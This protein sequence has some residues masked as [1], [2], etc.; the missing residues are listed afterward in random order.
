MAIYSAVSCL[1]CTCFSAWHLALTL[2]SISSVPRHGHSNSCRRANLVIFR[3]L[4]ATC[5]SGNSTS[6]RR[7]I[8]C[9]VCPCLRAL[10]P[11]RGSW[12]LSRPCRVP[13]LYSVLYELVPDP[14][15]QSR[16]STFPTS[17]WR[18]GQKLWRC[19][20]NCALTAKGQN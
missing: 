12:P 8:S 2:I 15:G 16:H 13:Y 5:I 1:P 3:P 6:T 20:W 10:G 4:P 18:G 7:Y 14:T 9:L 11:A 17:L 19:G